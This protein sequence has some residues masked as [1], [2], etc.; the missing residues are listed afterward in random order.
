MDSSVPSYAERLRL[1]REKSGKSIGDMAELL[2]I[3]W[4]SYS[5]LEEFDNEIID[6]VSLRKL[7]L[8][9]KALKIQPREF[10]SSDP[11]I[12]P[13]P[14]KLRDLSVKIKEYLDVHH[15]TVFE[16]EDR[17]G[18]E[19]ASCLENPAE[20]LELN[21]RGLI[22]VCNELGLDWIAVLPDM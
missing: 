9:F 1:A 2:E 22:D 16:F 18:W 4:E 13:A 15:M 10:F 11:L 21:I 19:M 12:Q 7:A 5:D 14:I 3:S 8:L 6:C 17:V 20:F